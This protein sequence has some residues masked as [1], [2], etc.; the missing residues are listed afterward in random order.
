MCAWQLHVL[1][2]NFK[3]T[4]LIVQCNYILLNS[5]SSCQHLNIEE[6]GAICN[7]NF[8]VWTLK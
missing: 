1:G 8:G 3:D 7:I 2:V 6:R 4:L 5:A